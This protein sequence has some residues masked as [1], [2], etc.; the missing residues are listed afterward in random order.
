MKSRS[1]GLATAL[2]ASILALAVAGAEGVHRLPLSDVMGTVGVTARTFGAAALLWAACGLGVTR[3]LLPE[4]L[5]RY[6]L[7][8]VLP[9]GAC[10][11]SLALTVLG[12]AYVPQ[13]VALVAVLLAGVLTSILALRRQGPPAAPPEHAVLVAYLALLLALVALVPLYRSGFPTVIGDGSDA[14]LAAGTAEFLR[15]EHP[16]GTDASLPVDSVPLTWRSKQPIHYALAGVSTLSGLE[17]WE[18]LSALTAFVF[19]LTTVG[20]FLM[21]RELLGAGTAA[22]IAAVSAAGLDRMVFHTVMHPYFNQTWG[23]FAL[24]FA[25]VVGWWAVSRGERRAAVLTVLFLAIQAFA[26][27]LALPMA[28]LALVVC[29]WVERRRRRAREEPVRSLDLRRLYRGRRSLAW[30]VPLALALAVPIVGVIEKLG[31]GLNVALNPSYSLRNWAGD[32]PEFIPAHQFF[33]LSESTGWWLA[34]AIMVGLA[35]IAL[36]RLPRALA[37]GLA[38]MLVAFL[39][40][41]AWFQ[42]RDF[43]QYFQF[44]TLAFM[45][46]LLVACAVVGAS[47]LR[48]LDSRLGWLGAALIGLLLISAQAS[49]RQEVSLTTHSLPRETIELSSW[50]ERLPSDASI[51][52]DV[53]PGSQLWAAYMLAE[54]PLC[55]PFPIVETQYP[56]VR[57][58]READYILSDGAPRPE[59][60]R[61]TS[62]DRVGRPLFQNAMFELFRA[63]RDLPGRED[64]SREMVT[65]VRAIVRDRE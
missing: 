4:G 54:R 52:L 65:T 5:R 21:T 33:A 45:G 43:G 46:P 31:T 44:K 35:G 58:S 25:L 51:R 1:A 59:A 32:L 2:A 30:M 29:W 55:S 48:E 18:A 26:Y 28:A 57:S 8:W 17:T 61:L 24:P 23:Y 40:A 14:H 10:T 64:C 37:L 11:S 20:L 56:H 3:L 50:A 47:R 7:L 6:E 49:A 60:R 22:G 36:S 39:L 15:H 53:R 63:R 12:F 16:L 38:A 34:V 62:T 27:P 19:A 13:P 42:L 41:G 9:V